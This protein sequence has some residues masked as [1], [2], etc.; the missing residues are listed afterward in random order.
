VALDGGD[1]RDILDAVAALREEV[2]TLREDLGW[3]LGTLL[4]N[5]SEVSEDQARELLASRFGPRRS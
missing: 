5:V 3:V 1:S 4:V 2:S